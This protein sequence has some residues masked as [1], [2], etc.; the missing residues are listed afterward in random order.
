M[1]AMSERALI[2]LDE[3][4]EHRTIILYEA[5]AL[6][7]GREKA[8]DNQT[9]YI[10]RSLLSEGRIE[11]P[12]VLRDEETGQLRTEKLIKAGP[13]NIVTSTTAVS[14]HGENETRMLSVPSND[15]KAQTRA[16]MIESAGEKKRQDI[17]LIADAIGATVPK[18]VRETVDLVRALT[19]PDPQQPPPDPD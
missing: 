7:E 14:L 6:R 12:V 1:T 9:A 15:S 16:V 17:D 4:L 8:D 19:Q 10:V 13:T 18:S 5:V 2:Y 3:S 11:Y